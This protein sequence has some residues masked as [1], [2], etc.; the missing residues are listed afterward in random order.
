MQYKSYLLGSA[1]AVSLLMGIHPTVH[2]ASEEEVGSKLKSARKE[3]SKY[4]SEK[5]DL[6]EKRAKEW[7]KTMDMDYKLVNE[8]I[9]KSGHSDADKNVWRN[10]LDS[11]RSAVDADW[12]RVNTI[13]DTSWKEARTDFE[14]SLAELKIATEGIRNQVKMSAEE[15]KAQGGAKPVDT[16]NATLQ[17]LPADP[18]LNSGAPT[19]DTTVKPAPSTTGTPTINTGP[20][21][22]VKTGPG[23]TVE[24]GPDTTVNTGPGTTVKTPPKQPPA[25]K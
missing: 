9:N 21:T 22:T 10:Q 25:P 3:I 15:L 24:T 14:Y 23:S 20:G 13:Q 1:L 11:K 18:A 4:E 8:Q 2:A 7:M 6:Y 16:S 5:K 19:I 17:V 12:K